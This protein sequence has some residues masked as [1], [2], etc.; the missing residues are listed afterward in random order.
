MS[1][2]NE[3]SLFVVTT[4]ESPSIV[5][6]SLIRSF[7][8]AQKYMDKQAAVINNKV[9]TE[10]SKLRKRNGEQYTCDNDSQWILIERHLIDSAIDSGH[11]RINY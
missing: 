11:S 4:F 3:D 8:K 2:E 9:R 10:A 6:V 7:T 1:K 5:T